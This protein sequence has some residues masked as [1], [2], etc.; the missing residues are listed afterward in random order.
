[1]MDDGE[2]KEAYVKIRVKYA[3]RGIELPCPTTLKLFK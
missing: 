1:M 2:L 3:L